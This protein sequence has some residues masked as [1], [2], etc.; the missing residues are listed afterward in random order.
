MLVMVIGVTVA[1]YFFSSN[2]SSASQ[3]PIYG[4]LPAFSLTTHNDKPFGLSQMQGKI[5]VVDFIFTNC[6]AACP[7]MTT[8]M[9]DIYQH[10]AHSPQVQFVSISVDPDNDT[11]ERLQEFA[12]GY[13]VT[14]FRWLFLRGPIEEVSV[15]AE[16]GFMVSGDFPGNHSTKFILVDRQGKIRGFYDSFESES[17]KLLEKHIKQ[18]LK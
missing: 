3:L 13:G 17:L 2:A 12:Q 5:N 10:F 7:R 4:Q 9:S 14:D 8:E 1:M 11:L 18:L 15:L 16:K 6:A